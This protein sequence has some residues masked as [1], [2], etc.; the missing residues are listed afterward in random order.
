[1]HVAYSEVAVCVRGME[2]W[3]D[4]V[5]NACIFVLLGDPFVTLMIL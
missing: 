3:M 1:M 5:N 2:G 4:G